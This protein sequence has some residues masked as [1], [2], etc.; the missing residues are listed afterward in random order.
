MNAENNGASGAIE[1]SGSYYVADPGLGGIIIVPFIA[2]KDSLGQTF[3]K[4][5]PT[6]ARSGL[7]QWSI[8]VP[9]AVIVDISIHI[10]TQTRH[11]H[12][13]D[14]SCPLIQQEIPDTEG[15]DSLSY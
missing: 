10:D 4:L 6:P 11:A 14:T 2:P 9:R 3:G 5:N 1:E 7:E 8:R 15:T 12:P 13:F